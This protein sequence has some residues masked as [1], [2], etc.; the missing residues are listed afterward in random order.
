M[1]AG[2][3]LWEIFRTKVSPDRCPWRSHCTNLIEKSR[4]LYGVLDSNPI[5]SRIQNTVLH[6]YAM[7][8]EV[9]S[10]P[11]CFAKDCAEGCLRSI[12]YTAMGCHMVEGEFFQSPSIQTKGVLP[13]TMITIPNMERVHTLSW[14]TLG[15]ALRGWRFAPSMFIWEFTTENTKE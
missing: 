1:Y 2:M 10:T 15:R 3:S 13:K 5:M 14:D 7:D 6:Y 8:P 12:L 4:V 11:R 9:F